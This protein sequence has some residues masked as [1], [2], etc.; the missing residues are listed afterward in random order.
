M[1]VAGRQGAGTGQGG[2]AG[3]AHCRHTATALGGAAGM[4]ITVLIAESLLC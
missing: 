1:V 3:G 4:T 2:V